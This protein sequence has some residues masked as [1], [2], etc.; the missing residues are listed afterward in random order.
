LVHEEVT[1]TY[2]GLRAAT[3]HR[4]YQISVYADER[5]VCA[6]GIRSTGLT[7]S[8]AIAEYVVDQM[9]DAGCKLVEVDE[10]PAIPH[11]PQLGER[12]MRPFQDPELIASD[13]AFGRIVCFCERVTEGELSGALTSHIPAVDRGGLSRRTR[14]TNG[15]CQGFYCGAAIAAQL[16]NKG[17]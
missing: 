7:A 3:E 10:E 17:S 2:A 16:A 9:A 6:G 1:A 4:D 12:G 13:A 14:A 8:L 11:M 5:Y 15:R